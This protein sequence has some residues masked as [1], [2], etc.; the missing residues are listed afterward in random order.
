MITPSRWFSGGKGLNEFRDR[1]INDRRIAKMVDNPKISTAF[2]GED[3][4][5]CELF[6]L[7]P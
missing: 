6:P 4:R 5:R 2:R 1:M 7:G 3:S